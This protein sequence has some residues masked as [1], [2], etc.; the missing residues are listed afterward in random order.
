MSVGT[1][2]VLRCS[3]R[4]T[5]ANGSDLVNVFFF[6]TSFASAQTEADIMTAVDTYLQSCFDHFDGNMRT[7]TA[8]FDLKV[9]VVQWAGGKWV[10]VQNV[11]FGPWGSGLT[12]GSGSD[13]LPPGSAALGK[14]YTNLGKHT[15]KKF[16]GGFTEAS[17]D[18]GGNVEAALH[19]A[20]LDGLTEL[21]SPYVISAGNTLITVV[22]DYVGGTIRDAL[23]AAVNGT[24][25]Y[26]RRRR[27]G[28]GS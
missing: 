27:P 19:T 6:R 25:S 9:D 12:A 8:P 15:G 28:V 10:V 1:A 23:A 7:T 5:D 3:A 18:V 21:L 13:A 14:L 26:Q 17:C 24:W 20:I 22:L 11:G 2:K 16:F 4:W